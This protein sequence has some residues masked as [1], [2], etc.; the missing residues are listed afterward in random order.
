[1]SNLKL[2]TGLIV[3]PACL[4]LLVGLSVTGNQHK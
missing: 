2:E 3:I 4:A 1:M